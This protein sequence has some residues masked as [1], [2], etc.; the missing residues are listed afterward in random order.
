MFEPLMSSPP[1]KQRAAKR[2][3][4]GSRSPFASVG[5]YFDEEEEEEDDDLMKA[6]GDSYV[7]LV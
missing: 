1:V 6:A 2:R 5:W 4:C 3:G 7:R